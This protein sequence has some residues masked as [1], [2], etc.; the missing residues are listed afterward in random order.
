[1]RGNLTI[2]HDPSHFEGIAV[3]DIGTIAAGAI[4]LLGAPGAGKGTQAKR[5]AAE[6][7]VPH[8]ST[9]DVLRNHMDRRTALGAEAGDMISRGLLVSDELVCEMLAERMQDE[10]FTGCVI[11][12][13]FP[14]SVA[15]AEWLERFLLR[16]ARVSEASA[17]TRRWLSRLM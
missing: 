10:D 8:I 9:G 7:R 12:D 15:Q 16:R 3:S 11:L 17:P 13:G 2:R 5:I 6:Y 4:V 14:R 1:M